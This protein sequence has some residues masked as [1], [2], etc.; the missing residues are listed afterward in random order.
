MLDQF[1]KDVLE[2]LS[3][4]NKSLSSKY[5]YD[6]KG[7]E[8]FQ[9]IMAMPEYYLTRAEMEIFTTKAMEIVES[10]GIDKLT[11]FELIELGAGD[12]TKTIRLLEE[13]L[14]EKYDF[15]YIPI[16]ISQNALDGLVQMLSEKLPTL[17]VTAMQGT[18]F[19][20]L[21]KLKERN[22]PK[23]ILFLGS[24]LGNLLDEEASKF[25]YELG[26][27]MHT[28]DKILLGLDSIKQKEIVLPAY[29]DAAGIT[30]EFNLNLLDRINRELDGNFNREQ[31]EHLPYYEEKEG[32]AKSYIESLVEQSVEI[33]SLNKIF[34]F[35][36]GEK[37]HTE[38]SRKYSEE[39]L[40]K[41]LIPTDFEILQIHTDSK[42]LFS[43]YL[44]EKK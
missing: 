26:A 36:K 44:I 42:Q 18:Y 40:A 35:E 5:F 4:E 34:H 10:F 11:K 19:N 32:I 17:S 27:S 31:F 9:Q 28:G 12:G 41:I 16:D 43:D 23:I 15:E 1:K 24:N 22:E 7:D 2:G 3:K 33:K 30:R 29:N 13:L 14:K 6:K 8:L 37:I 25:L 20:I 38:I 39:I 21:S